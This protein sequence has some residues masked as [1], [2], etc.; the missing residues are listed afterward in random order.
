[1]SVIGT[2][3]IRYRLF[4]PA[5]RLEGEGSASDACDNVSSWE[6]L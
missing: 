6:A 4:R 3:V 1:M 2:V 5:R